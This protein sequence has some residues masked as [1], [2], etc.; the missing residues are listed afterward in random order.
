[1]AAPQDADPSVW[2]KYR[3]PMQ[4][5]RAPRFGYHHHAVHV[6]VTGFAW[7]IVWYLWLNLAVAWWVF[8]GVYLIYKWLIV[9]AYLAGKALLVAAIAKYAD[10]RDEQPEQP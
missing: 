2:V 1:M 6:V 5:P 3:F 8:V 10:H 9:G 4:Q 7:V